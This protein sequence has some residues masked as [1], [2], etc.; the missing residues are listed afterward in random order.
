MSFERWLALMHTLGFAHNGETFDALLEAYAEKHRHYHNAGHLDACLAS[1]DA[2][3]AQ[4]TSPHEM[5][6]ALWFHDAVHKPLSPHNERHSAEW[7]DDFLAR[8]SAQAEL[9]ERVQ[10]YI[11]ATR[12]DAA[13]RGGDEALLLDIDLAILGADEDVYAAYESA[14]RREYH[15]VPMLLYRRRRAQFLTAFLTRPHIYFTERFQQEREDR[16]RANLVRTIGEL[17]TRK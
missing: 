17:I 7:A 6:L 8:N 14:I 5:E 16:A 1:L 2:S 10:R 3:A 11:L 4:A 13:P 12:H 15:L 9:R